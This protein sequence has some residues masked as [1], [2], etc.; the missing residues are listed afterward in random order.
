MK[1]TTMYVCCWVAV[2][3]GKIREYGQTMEGKRIKGKREV[4]KEMHGGKQR[5]L[6]LLQ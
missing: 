3:G 4:E 2:G 6:N 1:R 5:G